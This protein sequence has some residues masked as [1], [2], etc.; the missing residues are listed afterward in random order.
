MANW[1]VLACQWAREELQLDLCVPQL[2]G[3]LE[4]FQGAAAQSLHLVPPRG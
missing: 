2:L 4:E 1:G 3:D